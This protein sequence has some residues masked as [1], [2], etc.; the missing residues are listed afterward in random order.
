MVG[1]GVLAILVTLGIPAAIIVLVISV[2]GLKRRVAE[3]EAR[4]G[5][6]GGRGSDGGSGG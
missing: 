2:S 3:L 1:L 5:A 4:A 6:L